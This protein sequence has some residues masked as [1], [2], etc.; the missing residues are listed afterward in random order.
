MNNI[1]FVEHLKVLGLTQSE[2]SSKCGVTSVQVSKWANGHSTVP[3]YAITILD[4][5]HEKMNDALIKKLTELA[6]LLTDGH[7]TILKF[8]TNYRVGLG[9]PSERDCINK[10]VEGKTLNEA[11]SSLL[12]K[13]RKVSI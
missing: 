10:M 8:T 2:F 13:T 9:T 4:L 12:D 1:E 11:I 6:N 5:L 3:Q 7:Y